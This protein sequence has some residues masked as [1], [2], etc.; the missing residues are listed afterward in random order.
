M[1][2]ARRLGTLWFALLVAALWTQPAA[3][4]IAIG[5]DSRVNPAD[6]QVTTFAVGLSFPNGMARLADGSLLVATSNPTGGSYFASTAE[7]LRFVDADADGVADGPGTIMY[8]DLAGAL[9]SLRVAGNLVF[10]TSVAAT[11]ERISILRMSGGPAAPYSLVGSL[12]FAFPDGWEHKSYALA[13]RPAPGGPANTWE[14]Y[15][16]VGSDAN[17]GQSSATVGLSG[18]LTGTLQG[19]SIYRVRVQDTGSGVTVSSLTRIASGLRNAAGMDFHPTTGDLY[20]EDNGIDGL[21]DPTE[22][23]SADELNRIAAADLG[24]SVP[25][26]GFPSDYIEYRT[27]TRV[28]SGG[29]QPL[30]AFQPVPPPDGS[31]SE[32]AS[33]IAFAPPG[34]PPGLTN[35]IFVGFHGQFWGAGPTNEE[36]PV[37]YYD[38]AT[39][40]YFHFIENLQPGVGHLDSLLSTSDALFVADLAAR[41]D[42]DAPGS[43]VIYKL[44][45][46]SAAASLRVSITAPAEGATVSGTTWFVLWVDGAAAGARTYT[47]S[48]GGSAVATT[49][50]TSS[51]PV[52]LPVNTTALANGSQPL[53][54]TVTDAA[55]SAGSAVRTVNVQNAGGGTTP[56]VASFTSPAAG[57]TVS[58]T[59]TVGMAESGAGGTPISFTLNIDGVDRF[60][61]SGTATTASLAWDTTTV[62]NGSRTLTVTVRD[63]AGHTATATR[64][65]NVQNAG[66]PPGG[67]LRVSITAPTEGATVSGRVWFVL[68]VAGAAGGTNTYVLGIGGATTATANTT[69]TGPVTLPVDTTVS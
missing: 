56:L 29:V 58:G 41:G 14:L 36:N 49:T 35:G 62:A 60:T 68:W 61:S 47:L 59:V 43:G 24:A 7:L 54:A 26:F 39:G 48:A 11:I 17:F 51:G 9:T 42:T 10:I 6:F 53:T 28:G 52:S 55:G 18:L 38:L 65:V 3:A 69:S 57:A 44:R 12:N 2:L 66:P 40:Q 63:G 30:V 20:F 16:N 31:E 8:S 27:G 25:S 21:A 67:S 22:P 50:T 37:V 13:V 1:P 32:G 23:L 5:G 34:F 15:F 64:T 19:G 33:G 45:R 4:Q 46:R